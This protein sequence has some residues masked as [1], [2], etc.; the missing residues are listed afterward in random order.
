MLRRPGR[1][2]LIGVV[3]QG[4]AVFTH[5]LQLVATVHVLISD[6]KSPAVRKSAAQRGGVSGLKNSSERTNILARIE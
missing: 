4:D 1:R 2:K 5:R 6:L 3:C